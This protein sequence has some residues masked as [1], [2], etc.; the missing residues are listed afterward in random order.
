MPEL[1]WARILGINPLWSSIATLS[2]L[3]C[4]LRMHGF[5][6]LRT[7]G[8]CRTLNAQCVTRLAAAVNVLRNWP[9]LLQV[10]RNI[11]LKKNLIILVFGSKNP[12]KQ[13][14]SP[15]C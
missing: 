13:P 7:S 3:G 11:S 1:T 15:S 5:L 4:K 9:E 8:S 12:A 10:V 2:L 6:S 14:N